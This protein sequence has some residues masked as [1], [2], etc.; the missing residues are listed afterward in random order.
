MKSLNNSED[1][2]ANITASVQRLVRAIMLAT[3]H[4][5]LILACC[6]SV[7]AQPQIL[8][9]LQELSSVDIQEIVIS[10]TAETLY[11][12][13]ADTIGINQPEALMVKGLESVVEINQLIISTNLMR[14]EFRKNLHCPLVLWVNDDILGKLVWLAPDLKNWAASTIRFDGYEHQAT[15]NSA[16]TPSEV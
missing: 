3:G 10:P 11:T 2:L 6:N 4:F 9:L 16:F 5:S 7:K 1:N 12:T 15:S 13:I 8:N 14:D